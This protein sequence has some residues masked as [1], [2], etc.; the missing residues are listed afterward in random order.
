MVCSKPIP[1]TC[2][3]EA[4]ELDAES[5]EITL[6]TMPLSTNAMYAH[7]GRRRF[8]TQK[9]KDNKEAMGWELRSQHRGQPLK[10]KIWLSV[11][12]FWPTLRNHDLDNI[13]SLLDAC[14]GILWLD[15]GQVVELHIRKFYDKKN[16]RVEMEYT[17]V[18]N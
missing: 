2:R 14:T 12:L 18:D 8:L 13:K 16:A 10:G 4:T 17:T 3:Q 6:K 15:D 1:T 5:M 11:A 7:T 9:A